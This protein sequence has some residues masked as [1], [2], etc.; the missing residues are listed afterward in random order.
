V[1]QSFAEWQT[2]LPNLV[3]L[4]FIQFLGELSHSIYTIMGAFF[5]GANLVT[6]L[7]PAWTTENPLVL[8]LWEGT[9]WLANALL[10]LTLAGSLWEHARNPEGKHAALLPLHA[11]ERVC[12]GPLAVNGSLL[13]ARI[14]LGLANL[15][16]PWTPASGHGTTPRPVRGG[17]TST[18][19][20]ASRPGSPSGWGGPTPGSRN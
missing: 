4:G 6:R 5:R 20:R 12:Y 8:T 11:V 14:V 9:R 16:T 2:V 13:L 1:A 18:R 17:A 10:A 15:S 19:P 3:A 7:P